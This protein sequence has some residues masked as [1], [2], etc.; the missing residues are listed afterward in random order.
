ML[1]AL[2]EIALTAKGYSKGSKKI[3]YIYDL[4]EM[5]K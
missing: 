5:S 3:A 1:G 4:I 2:T